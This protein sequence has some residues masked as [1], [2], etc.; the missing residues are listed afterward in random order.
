M[1][2]LNQMHDQE[3]L[4]PTCVSLSKAEEWQIQTKSGE[5]KS[6]NQL[7]TR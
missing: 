5:G 3:N 2:F 6:R 4:L 7:K 1:K